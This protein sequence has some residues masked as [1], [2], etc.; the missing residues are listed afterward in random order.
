MANYDAWTEEQLRIAQEVLRESHTLGEAAVDIEARIGRQCSKDSLSGA[1]KRHKLPRPGTLLKRSG[2]PPDTNNAES[3]SKLVEPA[4]QEAPPP[5]PPAPVPPEPIHLEAPPADEVPKKSP[6]KVI[7]LDIETSPNVVYTWGKYD[8]N[9]IKQLR[10]WEILCFAWKE[11]GNGQVRCIARPDYADETDKT[12]TH[13]IWKIVSDADVVITQN[14]DRFDLPKLRAKFVAHGFP[15]TRAF[16]SI[17]TKKIAKAHFGFFSNSLND[18]AQDLGLG[19][20]METGGFELWEGCMADDPEAWAKMRLYN[21]HDVVL[22][23]SVYLKIRAWHP[24]HPNLA[25]FD[26]A[27]SLGDCPVCKSENV[28]RV[29]YQV[30]KLRRATRLHCLDCGHW[31]HRS[32]GSVGVGQ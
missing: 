25:L 26:I 7:V 9:A 12:L 30:L 3:G 8:Q 17:D 29:G 6:V 28:K 5:V 20:K 32:P 18:I 14:G 2:A 13:E 1:F 16:K 11:L 23:E 24:T 15:P 19:A 31:F 4:P 22:L 21:I 10:G 27:G